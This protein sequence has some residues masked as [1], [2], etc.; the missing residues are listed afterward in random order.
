[1]FRFWDIL[2]EG[3]SAVE[4]R[5]VQGYSLCHSVPLWHS[6]FRVFCHEKDTGVLNIS[7]T[8]K[9]HAFDITNI[10]RKPQKYCAQ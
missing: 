5:S 8:T 4:V 7:S 6:I 2:I 3:Y 1:M 10:I 9:I